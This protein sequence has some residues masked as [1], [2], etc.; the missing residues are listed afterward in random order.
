[1]NESDINYFRKKLIKQ[2]KHILYLLENMKKNETIDSNAEMENELS[3]YDNH[4]ADSSGNLYDK[5][6]GLSL[7]KHQL[8]ILNEVNQALD[9]IENGSYGK[10]KMCGKDITKERLEYFPYTKY[11]V[12]CKENMSKNIADDYYNNRQ[13]EEKTLGN[14][15]MNGYNS[16]TDSNDV[17]V[18][19]NLL[20][21]VD[22]KEYIENEEF[23]EEVENV[24]NE[25]YKDQLPD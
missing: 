16:F 7:K 11:C 18:K 1:M 4:P 2:K 9:D 24:S 15:F 22:A 14:L 17:N 25:E 19:S 5:E 8:S 20:N 12:N 13:E 10:C 6:I 21:N 23:V 3:N